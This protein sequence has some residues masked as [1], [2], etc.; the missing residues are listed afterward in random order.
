MTTI[1]G[2]PC[3]VSCAHSSFVR[4]PR[5]TTAT[6]AQLDDPGGFTLDRLLQLPNQDMVDDV[7]HQLYL[8]SAGPLEA[9][10]ARTRPQECTGGPTFPGV[11]ITAEA[12]LVVD[13]SPERGVGGSAGRGRRGSSSGAP[14][15]TPPRRQ[16]EPL[17]CLAWPAS[18]RNTARTPGVPIDPKRAV[19][20]SLS[21]R[22]RGGVPTLMRIHPPSVA[23]TQARKV[24]SRTRGTWSGGGAARRGRGRS[25]LGRGL[26]HV[27][28]HGETC[29]ARPAADHHQV[30]RDAGQSLD[31]DGIRN[32]AAPALLHDC[33]RQRASE[34][35]RCVAAP[36]RAYPARRLRNFLA[37]REGSNA[38]TP[39]D[40]SCPG[41]RNEE[42]PLFH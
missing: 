4:S 3:G 27:A 9:L 26:A 20:I 36:P 11:N 23:V 39:E 7:V 28:L 22:P 1:T 25:V 40:R 31:G 13:G 17:H 34:C 37:T 21:Y 30:T 41:D 33:A 12:D 18:A 35:L 24:A 10:R 5:P 8:A 29:S 15:G 38:G 6:M 32:R 16:G 19:S 42:R 2:F 14:G